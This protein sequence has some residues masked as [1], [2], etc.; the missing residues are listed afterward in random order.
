MEIL[1]FLLNYFL[2]EYK[3]GV[4]LPLFELLKEHSFN[5]KET[6]FS[7]TPEIITPILKVILDIKD[8]ENESG[9][10]NSEPHDNLD[11]IINIADLTIYTALSSYLNNPN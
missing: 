9:S 6:F 5:L 4:F 1:L 2:S 10:E 8:S 3:G 11:Y 7:L